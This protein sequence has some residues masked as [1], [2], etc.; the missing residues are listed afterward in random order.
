M[1]L[2]LSL[3][4][5]RE[6]WDDALMSDQLLTAMLEAT[7]EQI[8]SYAPAS[9]LSKL[10]DLTLPI[11]VVSGDGDE[12]EESADGANFPARLRTALMLQVRETWRETER[13]GGVVGAGD[14]VIRT[15][16]MT[17]AVRKQLRPRTGIPKVR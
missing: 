11:T 3:D 9:L 6:D 8:A 15:D 13:D 12:Y 5:V 2:W 4:V 7:Q 14:V 17:R 16:D 10:D 1:A